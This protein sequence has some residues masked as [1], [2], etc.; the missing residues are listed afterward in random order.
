MKSISYR[1][2]FAAT[3]VNLSILSLMVSS[4]AMAEETAEMTLVGVESL[5]TEV[6]G[7]LKKEMLAVE[8]AMKDIISANAAGNTQAIA[9]IAK[10]VKDS[11]ILKQSLT[12]HQK[13]ELHSKLPEDFIRQ[14]Q[15]FHY[16][17]GMLAHA[18]EMK[19]PELINFYYSKLFEACSSCH[20][21][22]AQHRFPQFSIATHAISHEH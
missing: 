12:K 16:M 14:D 19:K 13:H 7:L 3:L 1:A 10:Q 15:E 22:Y 11:F 17:A 8:R 6:R 20:K 5:S 4:T 21:A 2:V 9:S 18:A